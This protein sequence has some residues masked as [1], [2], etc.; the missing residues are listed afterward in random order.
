ML[1]EVRHTHAAATSVLCVLQ[2]AQLC[3][4]EIVDVGLLGEFCLPTMA[5]AQANL[6]A[7]DAQAAQ[8]AECCSGV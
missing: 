3:V 1:T 7:P 2:P 5:H 8:P 4:S 6:L